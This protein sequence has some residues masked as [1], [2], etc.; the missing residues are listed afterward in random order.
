MQKMSISHLPE[1]QQIDVK[2]F[3]E[4]SNIFLKITVPRKVK[5]SIMLFLGTENHYIDRIRTYAVELKN[6]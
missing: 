5:K 6:Q 3:L 1:N 2:L 4:N